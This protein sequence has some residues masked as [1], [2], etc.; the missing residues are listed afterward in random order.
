MVKRPRMGVSLNKP[1]NPQP[2]A[3][4]A[5][6]THAITKSTTIINI[7]D[8]PNPEKIPATFIIEKPPP[9]QLPNLLTA[10]P[11]H[12]TASELM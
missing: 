2:L 4:A 1:L 9:L 6:R 5:P 10:I 7:Q 12:T 3:S 8:D 11:H